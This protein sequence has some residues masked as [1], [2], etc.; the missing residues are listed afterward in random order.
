MCLNIFRKLVDK[1]EWL[2]ANAVV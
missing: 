2:Q 1:V